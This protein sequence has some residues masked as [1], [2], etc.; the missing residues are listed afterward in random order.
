MGEEPIYIIETATTN[1]VKPWSTSW[2]TFTFINFKAFDELWI[3]VQKIK[4]KT[5]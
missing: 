1:K 5:S 4:D 2:K 3:I